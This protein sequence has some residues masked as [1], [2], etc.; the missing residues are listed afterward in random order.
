MLK[1]I[2]ML[3]GFFDAFWVVYVAFYGYDD[4]WMDEQLTDNSNV[5]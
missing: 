3:T 4:C 5:F 2:G 1:N